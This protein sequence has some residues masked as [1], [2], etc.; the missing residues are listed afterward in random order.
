MDGYFL[1][2]AGSAVWKGN[3]KSLANSSQTS[4]LIEPGITEP[5]GLSHSTSED[6]CGSVA[7][8]SP[9]LPVIELVH[10]VNHPGD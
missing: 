4:W 9:L 5:L 2:I 1:D 8:G 7:P 10:P 3:S 6:V